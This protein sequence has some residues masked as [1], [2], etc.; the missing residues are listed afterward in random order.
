MEEDKCGMQQ[1][2][3]RRGTPED[4]RD[5]VHI[6]WTALASES[7][8]PGDE[9]A[10]IKN[11]SGHLSNPTN[12]FILAI[13]AG[14][15]VVG[16]SRGGPPLEPPK[17]EHRFAPDCPDLLFEAELKGLFVLPE[18]QRQG[19]GTKLF[20][21]ACDTLVKEQNPRPRNLIVWSVPAAVEYYTKLGGRAAGKHPKPDINN[22]AVIWEDLDKLISHLSAIETS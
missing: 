11:W 12:H 13:A 1:V 5:V 8:S 19:L 22:I 6:V 4:A 21:R 9:E 2:S 14:Q 7:S 17:N 15:K 20:K 18:Y 10:A 16:F 3:F